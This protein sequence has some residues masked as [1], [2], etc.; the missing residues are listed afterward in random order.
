MKCV[1]IAT[2][3]KMLFYVASDKIIVENTQKNKYFELVIATIFL[4][5]YNRYEKNKFERK[6]S[7]N[8]LTNC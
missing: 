4:T 6:C 7:V 1:F 5:Y 2:S 8:C 3:C